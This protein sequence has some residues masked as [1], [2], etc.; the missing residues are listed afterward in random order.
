MLNSAPDKNY[1][2]DNIFVIGQI[3]PDT[4]S[5]VASLAMPAS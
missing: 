4:D 1:S 3:N 5:I 2:Y